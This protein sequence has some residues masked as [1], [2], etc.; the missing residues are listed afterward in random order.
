MA[1]A[2]CM[3]SC[4]S[5]GDIKQDEPIGDALLNWA[6][7]NSVWI[8]RNRS[9]GVVSH[10]QDELG[11]YPL[12][13]TRLAGRSAI[14]RY[15]R[16]HDIEYW[17]SMHVPQGGQV[18]IPHPDGGYGYYVS[19]GESGLVDV[20]ARVVIRSLLAP[21]NLFPWSGYLAQGWRLP[22]PDVPVSGVLIYDPDIANTRVT[23]S[24]PAELMPPC[25][26]T[27]DP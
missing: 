15:S 18:K 23:E 13:D 16:L 22:D 5:P 24:K 3:A 7:R 20:N 1:T 12:G 9:G 4:A 21:V 27:H 6:G 11:Q 17:V 10:E 25:P 14:D 8:G 19:E 26:M 2:V